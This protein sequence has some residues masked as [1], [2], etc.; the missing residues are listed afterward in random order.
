MPRLPSAEDLGARP[1]PQGSTRVIQQNIVTPDPRIMGTVGA[2]AAKLG[3]SIADVGEVMLADQIRVNTARADDAYVQY[4]RQLMDMELNPETGFQNKKGSDAVTRPLYNDYKTMREDARTK[5]EESLSNDNQ[6]A[7]FR[8]RAAIADQGFDGKIYRHIAVESENYQSQ[9][10]DAF[11]GQKRQEAAQGWNKPGVVETALVEMDAAIDRQA[12]RLKLDPLVVKNIKANNEST[13]HTD[14]VNLMIAEGKDQ[15]AKLYFDAIKERLVPKD[16]RELSTKVN[17]ANTYGEAIRAVDEVWSAAGPANAN[18]PVNLFD[19]EAMIREKY[20][21]QP[22]IIKEAI[23]ELR[24]RN[25]AFN[26]QQTEQKAFN[27]STVLNGFNSGRSISSLVKSP[28]FLSLDGASR[29]ALVAHMRQRQ[30]G[31][32]NYEDEL[33]ERSGMR[34]Y[35]QY[36]KPEVLNQMSEAQITALEPQ[37]GQRLVGSLLEA[38]RKIKA[39]PDKVLAA[40]IDDDMFKFHASGAGLDA[41]SPKTDQEKAKLGRVKEAVEAEI[42]IAQR[43]KQRELYREEKEE[44][45]KRIIDRKV[46]IDTWGPGGTEVPAVTVLPDQVKNVYVPLKEIPS[47]WALAQVNVMRS[48]GLVPV[49]M[50]NEEALRRMRERLEH[51]YAVFLTGAPETEIQRIMRGE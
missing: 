43:Q 22:L 26:A 1:V 30:S 6:R 9:V 18:A 19:M 37:M 7:L 5:L 31:N 11:I 20:S 25:T 10:F 16:L 47:D 21:D 42:S 50:T 23:S 2:A 17:T 38:H 49:N 41:Y 27:T 14:T 29:D 28:E 51:G 13:V 32:I 39:S 36:S 4:S 46:M 34:L 48:N 3:A 44:I 8:K 35:W 15:A 40:T 45:M 33:R 24:S 12:E